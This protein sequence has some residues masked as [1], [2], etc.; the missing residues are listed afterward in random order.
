MQL[1]AVAYLSYLFSSIVVPSESDGGC[2]GCFSPVEMQQTA[3]ERKPQLVWSDGT[4]APGLEEMINHNNVLP[5]L[6]RVLSGEHAA[7]SEVNVRDPNMCVAG[8]IHNHLEEWKVILHDYQDRETILGY[9][10]IR[11]GR[12]LTKDWGW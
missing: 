8:E 3:A 12:K 6:Q 1:P 7:V 2:G 4:P 10:K 5:S 11:F 9:K